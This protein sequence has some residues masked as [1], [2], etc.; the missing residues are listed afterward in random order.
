LN[1][2]FVLGLQQCG[3]GEVDS[4]VHTGMLDITVSPFKKTWEKVEEEITII[5]VEVGQKIVDQNIQL[6]IKVTKGKA[7]IDHF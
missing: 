7:T 2:Q 1:L 5:Q 3:S 6:E 4:V